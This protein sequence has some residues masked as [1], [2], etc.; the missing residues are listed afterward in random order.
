MP[1]AF[2]TGRE[3]MEQLA[4]VLPIPKEATRVT[5]VA[6]VRQMTTVTVESIVHDDVTKHAVK[7][8]STYRLITEDPP[9]E[10]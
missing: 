10:A 2:T 5:I 1:K 7:L 8:L 9:C 6:D 4:A 3:F